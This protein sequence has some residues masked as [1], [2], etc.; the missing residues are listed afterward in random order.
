MEQA[1]PVTALFDKARSNR[2]PMSRICERANV[3]T[4]TPSR[5]KRNLNS[6]NLA[7][8][9]KLQDALDAILADERRPS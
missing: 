7:T 1:N 6:P 2:V 3:Q 8:V 4:S 9:A 5:W